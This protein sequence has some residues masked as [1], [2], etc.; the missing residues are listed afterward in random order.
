M[1]ILM[2]TC[3]QSLISYETRFPKD[4]ES[5]RAFK[6][7]ILL[8]RKHPSDSQEYLLRYFNVATI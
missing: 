2:I 3:T 8:K 5:K 7:K 1:E 6:G 4:C